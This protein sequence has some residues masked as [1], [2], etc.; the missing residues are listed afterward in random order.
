[1]DQ[2]LEGLS[3]VIELELSAGPKKLVDLK[4]MADKLF[5]GV[6]IEHLLSSLSKHQNIDGYYHLNRVPEHSRISVALEARQVIKNLSKMRSTKTLPKEF[7]A[8]VERSHIFCINEVSALNVAR[9]SMDAFTKHEFAAG[10]ISQKTGIRKYERWVHNL[11][12]EPSR[13]CLIPPLGEFPFPRCLFS[14]GY[15]MSIPVSS[16]TCIF[17]KNAATRHSGIFLLLMA[18]YVNIREVTC[19]FQKDNQVYLVPAHTDILSCKGLVENVDANREY[20][21]IAQE[22][23]L[24]RDPSHTIQW[25]LVSLAARVPWIL[26]SILKE[27]AARTTKVSIQTETSGSST[28]PKEKHGEDPRKEPVAEYGSIPEPYYEIPMRFHMNCSSGNQSEGDGSSGKK[29]G[30]RLDVIGH[31]RYLARSGPKPITEKHAAW[32]IEHGYQ[33]C[34]V[35]PETL[36]MRGITLTADSWFAYKVAKVRSHVRGPQDKP[37]VPAVRTLG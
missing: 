7:L 35:L 3:S 27:I 25:G 28:D 22:S 20:L 23:G 17:G 31:E 26:D 14:F 13:S 36:R 6:S 24:E 18:V 5:G 1:M 12:F 29:L 21:D 11:C 4:A 8:G 2:L 32:L 37:Y 15:G 33:L 9:A 19:L 30:Y 10:S 34:D 16:K